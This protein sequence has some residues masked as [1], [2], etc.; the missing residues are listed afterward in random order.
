MT[1]EVKVV[2]N[3]HETKTK[4]IVVDGV[5]YICD[6]DDHNRKGDVELKFIKFDEK[7]YE[8]TLN[9]L[10]KKISKK[11]DTIQIVKQS[12]RGIPY[13]EF[14]KIQKEMEKEKPQIR[15]N[16]GCFYLSFGKGKKSQKLFLR[17]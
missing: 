11:V 4:V 16:R 7:K 13:S 5:K 3:I 1:E 15:R 17:E 6:S 14:I 8:E 9:E 10:S 12:L 2:A